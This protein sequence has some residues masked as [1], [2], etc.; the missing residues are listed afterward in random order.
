MTLAMIV[1]AVMPRMPMRLRVPIPSRVRVRGGIAEVVWLT[2][3]VDIAVI[4]PPAAAGHLDNV[5]Q[6]RGAG[7]RDGRTSVRRHRSSAQD[8]RPEQG[9]NCGTHR[10]RPSLLFMASEESPSTDEERLYAL[11][12]GV[13]SHAGLIGIPGIE[14]VSFMSSSEPVFPE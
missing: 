2:I 13:M 4:S 8:H 7:I 14:Q 10:S 12:I 6:C 3:P 5:R 9:Q 11:C 1:I